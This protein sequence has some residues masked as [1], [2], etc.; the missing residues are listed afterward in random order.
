MTISA[1]LRVFEEGSLTPSIPSRFADGNYQHVYVLLSGF[2]PRL[3]KA[4]LAG[5]EFSDSAVFLQTNTTV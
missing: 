3:R 2:I 4:P 5:K 1:V